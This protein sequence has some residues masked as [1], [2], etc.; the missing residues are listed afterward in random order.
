M[1][2][3]RITWDAKWDRSVAKAARA[4]PAHVYDTTSPL[5]NAVMEEL[6]HI[7]NNKEHYLHGNAG[8]VRLLYFKY[9]AKL[10]IAPVV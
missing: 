6:T 8:I 5:H 10:G 4:F 3:I 9:A 1:S 2:Q 7:A